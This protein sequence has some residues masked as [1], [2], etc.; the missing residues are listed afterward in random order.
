[1]IYAQARLKQVGERA[2]TDI[3]KQRGGEQRLRRTFD[4]RGRTRPREV[5]EHQLH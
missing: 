3:V 1:M 5:I 2:V 4:L